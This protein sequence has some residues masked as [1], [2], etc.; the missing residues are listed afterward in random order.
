MKLK[1]WCHRE[2]QFAQRRQPSK[3]LSGSPSR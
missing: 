1:G 3:A 2:G